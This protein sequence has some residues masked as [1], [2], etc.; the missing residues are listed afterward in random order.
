MNTNLSTSAFLS[1]GNA[2]VAISTWLSSV[3]AGQH[4]SYIAVVALDRNEYVAGATGQTGYFKSGTATQQFVQGYSDARY[5]TLVYS[6]DPA[7][8]TYQSPTMG[9]LTSLSYVASASNG[10]VTNISVYGAAS[11]TPFQAGA[12]APYTTMLDSTVSYYGSATV[13]T[14]RSDQAQVSSAATPGMIAKA[15]LAMVGTVQ[16]ENGCWVMA[17]TIAAEAGASLP[18]SSALCD[19][20]GQ[21]NGPWMVAYDG[22]KAKNANWVD[23]LRPG[24]IVSFIT[25]SGTGHITTVASGYGQSAQLVDNQKTIGSSANDGSA[26]DL[27]A[28]RPHS[29][30]SEFTDVDPAKVVVYRLDT[31]YFA[32]VETASLYAPASSATTLAHYAKVVDPAGKSITSYQVYDTSSATTFQYAG[33]TI[34]SKSEGTA[35]T[36]SS[37]D[38]VTLST[39]ATS[40]LDTLH[41]RAFNG[42]SWGDWTGIDIQTSAIP[43]SVA[44][45][46]AT[47]GTAGRYTLNP[48]EAGGPDY[49]QYKYI[50]ATSDDMAVSTDAPNVFLIGGSG[51]KAMAVH[52]GRNVLDGGSGSSFLTGGSGIDTFFVDLQQS[53]PVWDTIENFHQGDVLTLWGWSANN[54]AVSVDPLA[55]AAGHQGATLRILDTAGHQSS[56]TF[57]GMSADQVGR[58]QQTAGSTW[59]AHPY[60]TLTNI[61]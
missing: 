27:I 49:L 34:T 10:D 2:D 32:E 1:R 38:Q 36:V 12:E 43:P 23:M 28:T 40:G 13:L 61:G 24:D 45:S 30:R 17:S 59:G 7:T 3:I 48:I 47:Q 39:T 22:E 29:Q 54:L 50:F 5:D 19:V 52:S 35:L 60:V 18:A 56:V 51:T 16:N 46:N 42:T 21:A 26:A 58:F 4:P 44:Y 53:A 11:A 9:A 33:Q 8:G 20:P 57:A 15:A 41:V 6:Y 31:P 25:S 14:P 37:L 55:G